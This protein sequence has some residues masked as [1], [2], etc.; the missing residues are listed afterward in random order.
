M[1]NAS[2]NRAPTSTNASTPAQAASAPTGSPASLR[3]LAALIIFGD[4]G[5]FGVGSFG[6]GGL[7]QH[8]YLQQSQ[9]LVSK[10]SSSS[11]S[12]TKALSNS[13]K[14]PSPHPLNQLQPHLSFH[15]TLRDCHPPHST[16]TPPWS[17]G[18]GWLG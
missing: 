2:L 14:Q 16:T 1:N 10:T 4:R 9:S 6:L 12:S 18:P 3:D 8:C 5:S 13:P 15:L 7:D 11:S 17:P